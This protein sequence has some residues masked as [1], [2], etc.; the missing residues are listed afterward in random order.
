MRI[1]VTGARGKVGAATVAALHAA[2]HAVT[3]TDL[4]RPLFEAPSGERVAYAQADLT[5]A[6]DAYAVVRGHDAVVHAAA[7]PEPTRNPPHTV[8]RNNLMATF[9]V[10]AAGIRFGARHI[11]NLSASRAR[12]LLRRAKVPTRYVPVDEDPRPAAGSVR[13][14]QHF[15][16]QLMD[17][18][19]TTLRHHSG[20]HPPLV[21][22]VGGQLRRRPRAMNPQPT[23]S[24]GFSGLHRRLR[25]G[26]HDP[27]RRRGGNAR[28]QVVYIASPA[29]APARRS[30]RSS[31][32]ST[33]NGAGARARPPPHGPHLDRQGH[34][35]SA[36]TR[37]ARRDYLD[38][39]GALRP[40]PAGG[41]ARRDQR[42]ARPAAQRCGV[43][44]AATDGGRRNR[45][46]RCG[47][48]GASAGPLRRGRRCRSAG[49]R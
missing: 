40:E 29:T 6:G 31:H 5:D 22:P 9:N 12:L 23:P 15:G 42:P 11:V 35:S 4:A 19:T 39:T 8:F 7:I 2:G 36:M 32:A 34:R 20:L 10:L 21:D 17:G 48:P 28:P 24:E 46:A 26:R 30:P 14:R 27:A 44:T 16:E 18:T 47:A 43:I 38:E 49:R 33:A 3:A 25:P 45:W 41:R 37:S 1:L 13:R